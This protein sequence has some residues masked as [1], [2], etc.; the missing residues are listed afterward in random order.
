MPIGRWL[1]AIILLLL[2][3][4]QS[5]A[6]ISTV[7]LSLRDSNKNVMYYGAENKILFKN[8]P[9]GSI[10][11]YDG[12]VMEPDAGTTAQYT[13]LATGLGKD[14]IYVY[15]DKKV[16]DARPFY[17]VYIPDPKAALGLVKDSITTVQRIMAYPA[18]AVTFPGCLMKMTIAVSTYTLTIKYKSG[19][20]YTKTFAGKNVNGA[21]F[22]EVTKGKV[23]NMTK[24][25]KIALE[26]IKVVLPDGIARAL[27]PVKV[28]IN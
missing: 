19:E 4:R 8:L 27:N 12:E 17:T 24:G 14:T 7:Q 3:S 1:P 26:N 18:I 16:I 5:S 28:E 10:I 23:K 22:D 25:D 2:I 9:E 11:K 21:E 13:I 15:K 6:Q 20:T